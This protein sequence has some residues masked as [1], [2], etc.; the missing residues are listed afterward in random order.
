MEQGDL[1]STCVLHP[2][3]MDQV[4]NFGW[5]SQSWFSDEEDL[6]RECTELSV[7]KGV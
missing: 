6:Q 7:D 5:I 3:L 1:A 2:H 4:P